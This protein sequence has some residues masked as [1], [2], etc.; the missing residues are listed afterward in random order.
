MAAGA[1]FGRQGVQMIYPNTKLVLILLYVMPIS[2]IV[3]EVSE[4][5][6][7]AADDSKIKSAEFRVQKGQV[8][9][10]YVLVQRF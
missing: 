10:W 3:A 6:D 7:E 4:G 2:N 1:L 8:I 9:L 5:T